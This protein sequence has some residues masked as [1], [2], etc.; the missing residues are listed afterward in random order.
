MNKENQEK[1]LPILSKF[2]LTKSDSDSYKEKLNI[3]QGIEK[4]YNIKLPESYKCFLLLCNNAFFSNEV[5]FKIGNS[6]N[7]LNEIY[8]LTGNENLIEQI[9]TF[10]FRMPEAI[11]PI[12]ES[13]NG[14]QI[15][16]G[17]K[18]DKNGKI[19]LWEHENELEARKMIG[20]INSD[21]DINS[22]YE[23]LILINNSFLDFLNSLK[24]NG[25]IDEGEDFEAVEI[26]LDDDLLND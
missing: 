21:T 15:C 10:I 13:P 18:E 14:D 6:E 22:Y 8:S 23:N 7:I 12:G 25:K 4:E 16:I 24:I 2:D 3:I 11:I 20:E 17:V 26:W 1:I 19:Y 9:E 5:I